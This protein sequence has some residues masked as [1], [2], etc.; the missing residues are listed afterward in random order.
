MASNLADRYAAFV[1]SRCM[2]EKILIEAMMCFIEKEQYLN[3]LPVISSRLP[4]EQ[5]RI[6]YWYK[7]GWK[8][9]NPV[10]AAVMNCASIEVFRSLRNLGYPL[11]GINDLHFY[12]DPAGFLEIISMIMPAESTEMA[13]FSEA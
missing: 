6:E 11:D 9:W 10:F 12:P 4:A 2:D 7:S 8:H 13:V 5:Y 3:L 1:E